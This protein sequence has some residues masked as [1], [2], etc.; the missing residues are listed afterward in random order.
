MKVYNR[1]IKHIEEVF[2]RVFEVLR[3]LFL[4]CKNRP[5]KI[6][7]I[8]DFRD[9]ETGELKASSKI[10]EDFLP[11]LAWEN[12]CFYDWLFWDDYKW[13]EPKEID[14]KTIVELKQLRSLEG[15]TKGLVEA[16]Q[17]VPVI[18]PGT[19]V[20]TPDQEHACVGKLEAELNLPDD[21]TENLWFY[22]MYFIGDYKRASLWLTLYMERNLENKDLYIGAGVIN[23]AEVTFPVQPVV[24]GGYPLYFGAGIIANRGTVFPVQVIPQN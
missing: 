2:G 4:K 19:V 7:S 9:R 24:T 8:R 5:E 15:T 22:L 3:N 18:N 6:S 20:F 10:P 11:F 1:Y 23:H 16:V 14:S 13:D 17:L 21:W 12:N